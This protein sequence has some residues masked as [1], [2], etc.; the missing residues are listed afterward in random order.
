M[1]FENAY[2]YWERYRTVPVRYGKFENEFEIVNGVNGLNGVENCRR[3]WRKNQI[4]K[5]STGT[6][7]NVQKST[8]QNNIHTMLHYVYM[9]VGS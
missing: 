6:V 3:G 4:E 7:G 5:L 9:Y 2:R 8:K 1:K